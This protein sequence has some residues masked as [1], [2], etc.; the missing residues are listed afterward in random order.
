MEALIILVQSISR[1][2]AARTQ[3]AW[4]LQIERADG[5]RLTLS[6]PSSEW[7]R[8]EALYSLFLRA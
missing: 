3:S 2:A 7:S 8:I 5:H 1:R 6:V 4:R